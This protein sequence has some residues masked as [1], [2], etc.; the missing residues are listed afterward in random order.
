M[1]FFEATVCAVVAVVVLAFSACVSNAAAPERVLYIRADFSDKPIGISESLW[2]ARVT[3]LDDY[4]EDF[5]VHNTYGEISE[6]QSSITDVFTLGPALTEDSPFDSGANINAINSAMRNAAQNAGWSVNSFD[7]VIL[8]FPGIPGFPAGALGTPGTVWLPGNNPFNGGYV[9]EFGHALGLGHAHHW[10]GDGLVYPGEFRG[11]RDGLW[12]MGSDGNVNLSFDGGRRAPIN[13]PMRHRIGALDEQLVNRPE[14][15]GVFRIHEF[16]RADISGDV[17]LGRSLATVFNHDG[18]EFWISFAPDLSELWQGFNASGWSNGI[19]VSDLSGAVT[20]S[21]DFTPGS[22]GGT[23][24]E[25]DYVDSRDGALVVGQS[26]TFPNSDITLAPL[27]TGVSSDGVRWIDVQLALDGQFVPGLPG[28]FNGD[29][30]V[31]LNDFATLAANLFTNLEDLPA[32][33][34]YLLGDITGDF[35]INYEDFRAFESAY[36]DFQ[37]VGAF[38]ALNFDN[39]PEPKTATLLM[40]VC[41]SAVA[42]QATWPRRGTR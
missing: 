2:H 34:T 35:Q 5:W 13:L 31:D 25:A 27:Q 1:R 36:D 32:S 17:A 39:V 19:V 15:S 28:D 33:E 30:Q 8:L 38:A 4:A 11:G 41:L 37:G 6:F 9:H 40:L 20:H 10:E 16:T 42:M 7:Q 12:M 26:Y 18:N 22:Q 29:L 24:N 21:L 14:E 3:S 23:G